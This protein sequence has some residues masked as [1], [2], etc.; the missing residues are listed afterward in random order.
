MPADLQERFN[1]IFDDSINP[2]AT[3]SAEGRIEGFRRGLKLFELSPIWGVGAG[4]SALAVDQL[5]H[6]ENP[7]QLHNLYGQLL[8]E[9]GVLGAVS[10]LLLL[11]SL[12]GPGRLR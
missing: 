1:T 10:F 2:V 7:G 9:L 4:C 6:L 12:Y 11:F 8:S 3:R 5:L